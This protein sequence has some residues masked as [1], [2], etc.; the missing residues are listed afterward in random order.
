MPLAAYYFQVILR[1][2]GRQATSRT[3]KRR[4]PFAG[5]DR[6]QNRINNMNCSWNGSSSEGASASVAQAVIAENIPPELR[7]LTQWVCWR[8]ETR[9]GKRTK[10]PVNPLTGYS[11]NV[12]DPQTWTTFDCALAAYTELGCDGV[13]FVFTAD[14]DFFGIDLDDCRNPDTGELTKWADEIVADV[15]SYTEISPS[16]YGL[17]IVARHTARRLAPC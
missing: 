5:N 10:V 2:K 13:G 16:Q 12:T 7:E 8:Y 6:R 17:K 14:D 11:A 3:K 9:H 15:D 4:P 1:K